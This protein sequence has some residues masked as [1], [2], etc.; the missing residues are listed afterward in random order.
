MNYDF[1]YAPQP[2]LQRYE[3]IKVNGEA[4]ARNFRMLPN[5][6][7]LLLD[8]TAP[9]VWLAQSDGTGYMTVTPY[10]LS[11]HTPP[12]TI[13][14]NA[15]AARVQQLEEELLNVRQSNSQSNRQPKKQQQQQRQPQ[16][17]TNAIDAAS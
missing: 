7:A 9:I 13:D 16:Q 17:A 10:D 3:I 6:N 2:M 15:L 12:E 14:I 4:G 8:E 5:S 11:L 1:N